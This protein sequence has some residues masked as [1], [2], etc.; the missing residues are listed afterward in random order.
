MSN[1]IIN[2]NSIGR[3]RWRICALLFFATTINYID[4][5]VLGILAPGLQREFSWSDSQYG[6]MVSAF[7][8]AYAIGFLFMGHLMDRI[9]CRLGYIISISIWSIAAVLHALAKSFTGFGIFRFGLGLGESGNFPAAVKVSAEWFP[10]SERSLVNGIFVSGASIGAIVAPLIVPF[11]AI[12]YGWQWAFIVTGLF[13]FIWLAFWIVTYRK[14]EDHPRLS[15]AELNYIKKDPE[16][17]QVRIPWLK[18]LTYRQT[19]AFTV[20]KLLTDPV[21]S[22]F[23]FFLPKFFYTQHGITLDKIGPPIMMIYLM[24]DV[25]SIVG[26]WLSSFLMRRDWSV[27]KSRKTTMLI[28]AICVTPV[29]FA[30][31]TD[32]LWTSVA[33][34]GFALAAHQAWSANLFTLSSDMFP[35]HAVGSVVGIGSMFGAI[36]GMFG[37]T[38]AG[39]LLEATGSYTFLFLAA[40][41]TYLLALGLI[42]W[43][44]PQLKAATLE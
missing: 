29:Y 37:A 10:K 21:F 31:V 16:E 41:C 5:Q 18:L 35:Q 25:G 36:G 6:M 42:H 43:L 19:W 23:F 13:G 9:G 34:I 40:G 1:S 20:A 12:R 4:R 14:P 28:A 2:A 11:I 24:S 30:S 44:V 38:F 33:L 26:G 3:Y 39:L 7:Q 27:N 15:R 22:F 32:D 17:S 8:A